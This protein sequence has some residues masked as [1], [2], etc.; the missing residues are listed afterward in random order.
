[1]KESVGRPL[2]KPKKKEQLQ[3]QIE[4]FAEKKIASEYPNENKNQD[5][6]E[7]KFYADREKA[8]SVLKKSEEL[9]SIKDINNLSKDLSTEAKE[10]V[11]KYKDLY[12]GFSKEQ[13]NTKLKFQTECISRYNKEFKIIIENLQSKISVIKTTEELKNIEGYM[14]SGAEG[15]IFKVQTLLGYYVIKI[16]KHGAISP[17]QLEAMRRTKDVSNVSHLV[18]YSQK[19]QAIVMDF[20]KG[21]NLRHIKREDKPEINNYE[22]KSILNTF[23]DLYERDIILDSIGNNILFEE[24]KG[25]FFVD[26]HTKTRNQGLVDA[27]RDL[28][29]SLTERKDFTSGK[30]FDSK[31]DEINLQIVKELKQNFPKFFNKHKRDFMIERLD[32]LKKKLKSLFGLY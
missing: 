21:K 6:N 26:Y 31:T 12:L 2:G 14:Y 3:A 22:I 27:I 10:L 4:Y 24:G 13:N 18:S 16:F 23:I 30:E 9:A 17:E 32:L 5:T 7:K 19:D 20:L 11:G 8:K 1:M 29:K 28:A 25:F 15:H